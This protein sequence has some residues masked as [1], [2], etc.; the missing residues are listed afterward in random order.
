M[1]RPG[2]R[3]RLAPNAMDDA[4]R[5]SRRTGPVAAVL[6]LAAILT[7]CR[8]PD[9]HR[10]EADRAAA[11]WIARA[12]ADAPG[13]PPF[14]I[15]R[16]SERFRQQ[17]L[18]MQALPAAFREAL[19]APA[20]TAA[21]TNAVRLTL[22]DCLRIAMENSREYQEAREA[23]FLAALELDLESD[24]FRNS[25]AGLVSADYADNR[26]GDSPRRAIRASAEGGLTRRLERGAKLSAK[27]ALDVARMLTGDR[28]ATRGVLADLALT[29]P[30]GRGAGR[31]VVTEPLTQAE[32]NL[33]YALWKLERFKRSLA[34]DVVRS[35][36]AVLE[37]EQRVRNQRENLA[38]IAM[39]TRRAEELGRAGRISEI[40]VNLSRQTELSARDRLAVAIES[41]TARLDQF[42]V[43]LGLPADA[44]IELDA[45][46]LD[47]LTSPPPGDTA[48][49]EEA[50]IREALERR[51]DLRLAREQLEDARRRVRVAE[52]ALRAGLDLTA[53]A[54][55]GERRSADSSAGGDA[56]LRF[57]R[58]TYALGLAL[59]L[60][61]ER[62]AERNAYR[63]S[64]IALD[65]A[66]RKLEAA[67][68]EVKSEVRNVY[69]TLRQTRTVCQIQEQALALARRRVESTTLMLEAGRAEMRDLVEARDALLQ[70]QNALTAARVSYRLAEL[71]FFRALE[72]L[73][74]SDDG[75]ME[76]LHVAQ[77]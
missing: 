3:F 35:Y 55:A 2:V 49:T 30:L 42:K 5:L 59:D 62:T 9:T 17:L 33:L 45:A 61:W 51:L 65:A 22:A 39:A 58:G 23:V 72:R 54:R 41:V 68:D 43:Q 11:G 16:P 40:Q 69:R 44:R 27:L 48:V 14:T 12:R 71:D 57:D 8:S 52:D 19:A 53:S 75:R 18:A 56:E 50:A 7:A 20:T 46:D 67:E 25:L 31:S 36:Y 28:D 66:E 1:A 73:T 76:D 47:A 21:T 63:Q 26:S 4:C 6:L 15:E 64:L 60:P 32:R 74:V 29:V 37:L 34:V 10:R 38:G 77:Q 13:T 70:A 24:A